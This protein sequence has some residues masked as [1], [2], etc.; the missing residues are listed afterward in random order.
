[1]SIG[2]I[3]FTDVRL[4][5]DTGDPVWVIFRETFIPIYPMTLEDPARGGS[6]SLALIGELQIPTDAALVTHVGALGLRKSPPAKP[7]EL[8]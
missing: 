8:P 1:L 5:L 6:F 4:L 3:A 7:G 2:L